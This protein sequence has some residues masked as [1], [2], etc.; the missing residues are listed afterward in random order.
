MSEKIELPIRL[1]EII[2]SETRPGQNNALPENFSFIANINGKLHKIEFNG[3]S[4]I[5]TKVK[6]NE[7]DYPSFEPLYKYDN[8]HYNKILSLLKESKLKVLPS[9]KYPNLIFYY[10]P[11]FLNLTK[12]IFSATYEYREDK[13]Y[14]KLSEETT[15]T[16]ELVDLD[17][18]ANSEISASV[19]FRKYDHLNNTYIK[20]NLLKKLSIPD[21]HYLIERTSL[22][23]SYC[24]KLIFVPINNEYNFIFKKLSFAIELSYR[25]TFVLNFPKELLKYKEIFLKRLS[26]YI[27]LSLIERIVIK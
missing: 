25:E 17:F 20:K 9:S 27:D 21:N 16:I 19:F 24:T 6:N 12:E 2:S 3:K 15:E 14:Y 18:Y 23:E 22:P 10:D 8:S 26:N 13:K 4:W 7:S 5:P 11:V 1:P